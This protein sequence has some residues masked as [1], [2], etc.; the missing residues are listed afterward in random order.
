MA[1][2]CRGIRDWLFVKGLEIGTEQRADPNSAVAWPAEST[3]GDSE[4][5]SKNHD[6]RG[7]L[8]RVEEEETK[9]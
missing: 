6:P 3:P 2:E 5:K 7:S 9:K 1:L 4:D 8:M